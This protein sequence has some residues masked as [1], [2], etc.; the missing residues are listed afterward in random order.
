MNKIKLMLSLILG[1]SLFG[2]VVQAETWECR[3]DVEISCADGKCEAKTKSDFTPM[4]VSFDRTGMMSVCAYS[5]CWEGTGKVSDTENFMMLT[6]NDLKFSTSA[7]MTESIA[8]TL[9]K[10]DYV[11]LIKVGAFA[12]PL[13]CDTKQTAPKLDSGESAFVPKGW[14]VEDKMTGDLN[15]DSLPDTVL[16][17]IKENAEEDEYNRSL[18]ILFKTKDGKFT[19]AAEAKK[20]IRCSI[21]GGM[22]GGG[23]A[24]IKIEN[25]VLTISQLYGSREALDYLHRFRYEPSTKKFLLIGED[26]NNYDRATGASEVTSSNYLTGKQTITKSQYNQKTDKEDTVS[27]KEKTVPKSKKYI[28]DVDYDKY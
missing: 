24:D 3:N 10:R 13:I 19:K 15:G 8:I 21:C 23:Q 28:E 27:K 12:Q 11:A 26:I 22:L 1:L 25:G 14:K 7:D 6:G 18:L 5:G 4:S 9:D 16:Q 20:I 17:I 2:A